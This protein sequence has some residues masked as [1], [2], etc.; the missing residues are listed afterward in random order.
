MG[1]EGESA[2]SLGFGERGGFRQGWVEPFAK[3][4]EAMNSN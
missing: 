4:I 1:G 2:R 3:P